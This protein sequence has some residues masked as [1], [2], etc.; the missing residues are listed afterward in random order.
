MVGAEP[1]GGWFSV[2][3]TSSRCP[4][5]SPSPAVCFRRLTHPADIHCAG[6]WGPGDHSSR[7]ERDTHV[8]SISTM[9]IKTIQE[10]SG[11]GGS[12]ATRWPVVFL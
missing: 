5:V 1:V 8:F 7:L 11:E 9:T 10:E 2:A 6:C 4:A 3:L 12:F